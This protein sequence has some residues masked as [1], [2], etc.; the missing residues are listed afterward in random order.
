MNGRGNMDGKF[1][2][3]LIGVQAGYSLLTALWGLLHIESFMA[4]TGPKTDIWLVKT[5]C[6]LLVA[7]SLSLFSF[8]RV[9]EI[10]HPAI[11]L[12]FLTALGLAAIDIY[13]TAIDRIRWVY[14]PDAGAEL[15]IC[16][17]WMVVYFR[18]RL[19]KQAQQ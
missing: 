18:N 19:R 16:L 10:L 8:L 11:I 1:Y 6:V 3:L 4:V 17:G 15:L 12:G 13:Y 2:R 7:I 14:L 9:Q 5:V